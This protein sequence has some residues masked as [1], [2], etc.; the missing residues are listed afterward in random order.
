MSLLISQIFWE[1]VHCFV[2]IN[3]EVLN[4][5]A[6]DYISREDTEAQRNWLS[7]NTAYWR[8]IEEEE[9]EWP[10]PEEK[11]QVREETHTTR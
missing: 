6:S 8:G 7:H 1:H 10:T 3:R 9:E 4:W 5:V 2:V 11:Q